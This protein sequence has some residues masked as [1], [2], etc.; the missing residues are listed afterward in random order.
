MTE[1]SQPVTLGDLLL[2]LERTENL[3][4]LARECGLT[5]GDLK[6]RLRQWRR[7]LADEAEATTPDAAPVPAAAEPAPATKGA[8]T[9]GRRKPA[10]APLPPDLAAVPAA[11]GL[12]ASPLPATGSPVLEV[13]TDGASRGNPGPASVGIV[14]GL[15]G[16][17]LLA[18]HAE[19]IGVATNNV[20]EYRAVLRALELAAGWGASR[21]S[22]QL[23]SELVARQ[24]S[25]Q[26][27]VKSQDLLPFYRQVMDLIREL[28]GFSVRHIRRER[29]TLADV[30]ANL[31]LDGHLPD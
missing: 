16:G 10:A 8:A 7:E 21:I 15:K 2:A 13:W 23:D 3:R 18:R 28:D 30:L 4:S 27:R 17:D 29:N 14:F 12:S 19:T 31:A 5:P 25:G 26:Y 20:A 22:L 11:T 9:R 1:P 24:I 6:R